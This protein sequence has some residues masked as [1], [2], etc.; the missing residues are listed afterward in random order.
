MSGAKFRR[1]LVLSFAHANTYGDYEM[2]ESEGSR[3]SLETWLMAGLIT[4]LLLST[5]VIALVSSNKDTVFSPYD[6]SSEHSDQQL[7]VM[8]EDLGADGFGYNIILVNFK[9]VSPPTRHAF[10]VLAVWKN[11]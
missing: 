10:G 4:S 5:V 11:Q 3:F 9:E 7:T 1:M 2:S 8:R 6:N